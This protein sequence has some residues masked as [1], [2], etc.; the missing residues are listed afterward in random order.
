[1][2]RRG[3][4]KAE[5]RQGEAIRLLRLATEAIA[6][7]EKY[8]VAE[9]AEFFARPVRVVWVNLVGGIARGFGIAIGFTLVTA[10]SLW[11]L[12]KLARLNL[13]LIGQFVADIARIVKYELT[14]SR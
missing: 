5:R 3:T 12:G 2:R 7:W 8:G 1:M 10:L 11:L 9:Y 6:G 4:R 14:F 13:P